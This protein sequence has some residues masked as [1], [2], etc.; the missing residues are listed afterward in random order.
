M[1]RAGV[2]VRALLDLTRTMTALAAYDATCEAM[3]AATNES[4]D[5]AVKA[6]D[7]ALWAVG[8]AFAADTADRNRREE[9]FPHSHQSHVLQFIRRM[10]DE[11][12]TG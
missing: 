10:A 7:A 11:K 4:A 8:E 6:Y 12:S 1:V 9:C 2:S 5:R 3:D